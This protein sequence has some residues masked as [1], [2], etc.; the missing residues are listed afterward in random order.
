MKACLIKTLSI[1]VYVLEIGQRLVSRYRATT[2]FKYSL[3]V[4]NFQR[5][6]L[7]LIQYIDN[8]SKQMIFILGKDGILFIDKI[9]KKLSNCI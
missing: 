8:V 7:S 2:K 3:I 6:Q 5:V 4:S 9:I 1:H